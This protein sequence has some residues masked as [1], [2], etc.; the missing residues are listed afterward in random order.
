MPVSPDDV[1]INV[2]LGM[3]ARESSDLAFAETVVV[4]VIPELVETVDT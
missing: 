3:L 2:V 4:T 1:E